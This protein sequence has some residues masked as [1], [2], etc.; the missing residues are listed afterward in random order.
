MRFLPHVLVALLMLIQYP[1]WLGKGG[2]LHV[3]EM[4][5]QLVQQQQTNARQFQRNAALE[6][7]VGD[8]KQGLHAIEELARYE[9]GMVRPDEVYVQFNGDT[10][11]AAGSAPRDGR[12]AASADT[13]MADA[14]DATRRQPG[15]GAS[16]H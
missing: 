3:W 4:D 1:L 6:N 9:L 5:R 15:R 2:W 10:P 7:E 14:R 8:L 12:E 11:P 16:A 13:R